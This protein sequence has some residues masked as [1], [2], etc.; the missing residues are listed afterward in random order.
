MVDRAHV[1][2]VA[3][4]VK[5]SGSVLADSAKFDPALYMIFIAFNKG[6]FLSW[7]YQCISVSFLGKVHCEVCCKK[8]R[9]HVFHVNP[10]N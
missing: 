7:H 5:I 4:W 10:Y 2:R 3:N 8:V 6:T 9:H 1:I